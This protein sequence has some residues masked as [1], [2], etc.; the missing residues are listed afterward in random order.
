VFNRADRQTEWP[1]FRHL[2]GIAEVARTGSTRAAAKNVNLSQP[3]ISQAIAKF[4]ALVGEPL[5]D[6]SSVGMLPTAA[7][8]L[9]VARIDRAVDALKRAE[10]AIGALNKERRRQAPLL[11]RL[12]TVQIR[13]IIEVVDSG[14]FTQAARRLGL[15]QPSVH[16]A[17]RDLERLCGVEFFK[18]NARGIDVTEA[19]RMFARYAN[20]AFGEIEQGFAEIR[21]LR[22]ILDGRLVIGCQRYVLSHLVPLAVTRLLASYPDVSVNIIDGTYDEL[23]ERLRHASIHMILGV[24]P[25]A[26]KADDVLH[27]ILLKEALT[28]IVRAKHPLL[29]CPP[30]DAQTLAALEWIAPPQGTRARMHFDNFFKMHGVAAPRRLIECRSTSATRGLLLQSDRAAFLSIGQVQFELEYGLLAVLRSPFAGAE[31]TIGYVV[32]KGAMPTRVQSTFI[33]M[34]CDVAALFSKSDLPSL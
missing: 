31:R 7:G 33:E 29:S 24:L 1:N 17:A 20:Q 16:R 26:S 18:T 27:E 13:A 3:A 23:L 8:Q 25:A 28:I 15:A 11:R 4:D 2:L 9:L 22:G 19:G 34:L 32:S 30:A 10:S 14:G 12:T 5:F 6:R 21:E